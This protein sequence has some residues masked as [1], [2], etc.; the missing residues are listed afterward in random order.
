[1]FF[2]NIVMQNSNLSILYKLA[3]E[4]IINNGVN[5]EDIHEYYDGSLLS[6][7]DDNNYCFYPKIMNVPGFHELLRRKKLRIAFKESRDYADNIKE[8]FIVLRPIANTMRVQ[9]TR[10]S[11][12]FDRMFHLS[13]MFVI[14][15]KKLR[16]T[17]SVCGIQ[18]SVEYRLR[19]RCGFETEEARIYAIIARRTVDD[20]YE[21][22]VDIMD[23]VIRWA[24]N[25]YHYMYGDTEYDVWKIKLSRNS[26][27]RKDASFF[28]GGYTIDSIT[29]ENL[30]LVSTIRYNEK[31]HD[32]GK[33]NDI[34][35]KQ[36]MM[37]DAYMASVKLKNL[38]QKQKTRSKHGKIKEKRRAERGT[39]V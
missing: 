38:K 9:V 23:R 28:Y 21:Y 7:S 16:E 5:G 37:C 25:K 6:I 20:N 4:L 11:L 35:L 1:M 15:P 32:A 17:I 27:I 12:S 3:R 31:F 29:P 24:V 36:K 2:P 34:I 13:D 8:D 39:V 14:R 30:T 10:Y 26:D 33:L 19:T 22:C 18:P